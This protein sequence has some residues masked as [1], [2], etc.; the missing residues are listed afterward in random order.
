MNYIIFD[1]ECTCWEGNPPNATQEIIEIGALKYDDYG[2]LLG[3]FNKFVK[4]IISP[5]LSSYCK[6]LTT[7]EQSQ[8]NAASSFPKVIDQFWDWID[9]YDEEYTLC[10]WGSSDKYMLINDCNLHKIE[11]D[12]VAPHFNVKKAYQT[13]RKLKHPAGLFKSVEKEG[14]EFSG[15][16]HRA[17]HDADNLAKIFF[18]FRDSFMI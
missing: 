18:K 4:P 3:T 10:S 1:L 17:I 7:I 5:N 16:Q 6:E 13:I 9:I 15:T 11:I 14:F 12:W 2:D 8:I